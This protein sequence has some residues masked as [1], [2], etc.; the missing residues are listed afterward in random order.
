MR[1]KSKETETYLL[2]FLTSLVYAP[3][4]N[5]WQKRDSISFNENTWLTVVI[6]VGYVLLYLRLLLDVKTWLRVCSAFF[7][8]SIPIIIRSLLRNAHNNRAFDRHNGGWR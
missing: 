1:P 3:T 4:L 8:A 5:W 6:G 7:V 2:V